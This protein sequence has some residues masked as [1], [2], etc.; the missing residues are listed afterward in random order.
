MEFILK[1]PKP[2]VYLLCNFLK[3]FFIITV[4]YHILMQKFNKKREKILDLTDFSLGLVNSVK[5]GIYFY[6]QPIF[7]NFNII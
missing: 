7:N 2:V 4:F 1:N 6:I 3:F 5:S